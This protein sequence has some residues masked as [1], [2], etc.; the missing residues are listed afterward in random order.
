MNNWGGHRHHGCLFFASG[1]QADMREL[2]EVSFL[3]ALAI[4]P[5][6]GSRTPGGNQ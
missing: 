1:G 3:P 6:T 2:G 5:G 4:G